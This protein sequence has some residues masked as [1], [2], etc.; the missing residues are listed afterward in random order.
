MVRLQDNTTRTLLHCWWNAKAKCGQDL[1]TIYVASHLNN[2]S[3]C[4]HLYMNVSSS[5]I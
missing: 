1:A 2:L 3:P 4:N 5:V